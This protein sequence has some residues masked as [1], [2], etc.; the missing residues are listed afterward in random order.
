MQ[1]ALCQCEILWNFVFFLVWHW[2]HH[3]SRD[4][5]GVHPGK[6]SLAPLFFFKNCLACIFF[7]SRP[8][9]DVHG[10]PQRFSF[11]LA[12]QLSSAASA[13]ELVA[14]LS[15][16]AVWPSSHGSAAVDT[17]PDYYTYCLKIRSVISSRLLSSSR[18]WIQMW[19]AVFQDC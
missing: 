14:F 8:C 4:P 2:G 3:S 6:P 16:Y 11:V 9:V 17:N 1:A 15:I 18:I 10:W 5:A 7:C 12:S 19:S 13:A